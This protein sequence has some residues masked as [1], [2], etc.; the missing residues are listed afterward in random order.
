[1]NVILTGKLVCANNKNRKT[2]L[3][4]PHLTSCASDKKNYKK[5]CS[6]KLGLTVPKTVN[7]D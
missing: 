4:F 7:R 6:L 2:R 5:N 3:F 1:M